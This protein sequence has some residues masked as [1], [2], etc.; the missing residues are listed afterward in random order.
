[1]THILRICLFLYQNFEAGSGASKLFFIRSEKLTT[2]FCLAEGIDFEDPTLAYNAA[3]NAPLAELFT[4]GAEGH[5][6]TMFIV[7]MRL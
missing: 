7:V 1:M 4:P 5:V 2:H 6:Y 3:C